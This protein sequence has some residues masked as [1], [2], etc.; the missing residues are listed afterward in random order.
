MG[1]FELPDPIVAISDQK[2]GAFADENFA[3]NVGYGTIRQF[4]P[5]FDYECR[6]LEL[7]P[8]PLF[9]TPASYN[10]TGITWRLHDDGAWRVLHVMPGSPAAA[11]GVAVND[12]LI[13]IGES[14]AMSVTRAR[15]RELQAAKAGTPLRLQVRRGGESLTFNLALAQF[16][17][18]FRPQ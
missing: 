3:G 2:T 14:A 8:S 6:T 4:V 12:V 5:T 17:P 1:S 9:G 7:T 16:V 10:G 15:I 13:A 11:A 18:T